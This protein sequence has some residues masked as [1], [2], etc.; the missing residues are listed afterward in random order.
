M[1]A[2]KF[3]KLYQEDKKE[4][5]ELHARKTR[6]KKRREALEMM[7]KERM[8]GFEG[9]AREVEEGDV[10]SGEKRAWEMEGEMTGVEEI[11][12]RKDGEALEQ[13]KR[14]E[15]MEMDDLGQRRGGG[16]VASGEEEMD[17]EQQGED[18]KGEDEKGKKKDLRNPNECEDSTH[19]FLL[20]L[21]LGMS[22]KGVVDSPFSA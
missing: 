11:E 6:T 13:M 21:L 14:D 12:R 7:A 2:N 4:Q 9:S 16:I 15:E 5:E 1:F 17:E 10:V 8:L 22:M 18:E 19:L 3:M 20:E